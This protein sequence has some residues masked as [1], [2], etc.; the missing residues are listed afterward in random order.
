M[1]KLVLIAVFLLGFSVMAMA[2]D[3][4]KVEVFGGFSFVKVDTSTALK[5]TTF[6][7][8]DL[9]LKGWNGSIAINGNKWAG[10]VAD[11]GGYYGVTVTNPS[12][13]ISGA[14]MDYRIQSIMVGPRITL[15][16]GKASPFV[17]ALFGYA[18][19][20]TSASH[21]VNSERDF[22]MAIGGGV[23]VNLNSRVAIR[24]VQ[25]DSF[26]ARTVLTGNF[27]KNLRLSTGVVFK[28]GKS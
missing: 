11:F 15:S 5:G 1:K 2:Q 28:L 7:W 10:F 17:H 3:A 6:D 23:D 19:V 20:R 24:A 8:L 14:W 16:R 25:L 27:A 4:P 13:P 12:K 22:A 26:M 9:N 21:I 18:G